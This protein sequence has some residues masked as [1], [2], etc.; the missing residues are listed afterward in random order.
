MRCHSQECM[1]WDL[2]TRKGMV[3]DLMAGTTL[4]WASDGLAM[5]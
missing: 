2:W 3:L 1:G 4:T 5:L